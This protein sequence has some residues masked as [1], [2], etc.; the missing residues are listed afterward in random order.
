M[1]EGL[2]SAALK[3][4]LMQFQRL[5]LN[6]I[7]LFLLGSFS[8]KGQTTN[9][10][11]LIDACED[12]TAWTTF[13][14][15]GVVVTQHN[16]SG[17]TGGSVRFDV[18]FAKGSGYGGIIRNCELALPENYE[19]SFMMCAT[20]PVNNFEF[21]VSND[22]SGEDIWWVNNRNY[23]YPK[24][25]KRMTVKKRH[26]AFAWGPHASPKPDRLRRIEIVVTAGTGG[27]GSVW[28]DD[29]RL[30]PIPPVPTIPPRPLVF[31]S[32][33]R[34][35]RA[36]AS[37]IISGDH[38]GWASKSPTAEWLTIDYGYRKEF[39]GVRLAWDSALSGLNYDVLTSTDGIAFD[40]VHTVHNGEGGSVLLYT[41][42]SEA[43]F[44]KLL[45]HG[46]KS[47]RAF[48]LLKID[49]VPSDSLSTVNDY[50][51][52]VA[53][54]SPKGRYPRYFL[55]QASYWTVVGVASDEKEALLNEDGVVEVDKQH[56]SI[57]PY[58]RLNTGE[59]LTWANA[60]EQQS[61][62][63]EYLPIPTAK[64][65]YRDLELSVTVVAYGEPGRSA[66]LA[67]YVLKNTSL[68]HQNGRFFIAVRPFQVNP[69]YQ[70]LNNEGGVA[71]TSL[72]AINGNRAIVGDKTVTVSGKP[73]QSGVTDIDQGDIVSHIA[74][75]K[76]PS[77]SAI[78]D[79]WGMAS[80]GFRY[81]FN[82]QPGDSLVVIAS[83][84]FWPSADRWS[85]SKP[86]KAEFDKEIAVVRAEWIRRLNTVQFSLPPGARKY[87]DVVRSN[88]AYV[89]I[90]KDGPG[91]QPGS[92]SYERSW[93]RDGSMTSAALLKFGA[94][95]DVHNFIQW[96]SG[97]QYENGMV[98]CVVD[99]RGPDPVPENDSHGE[100][101]FACV[102]YFRFTKD[103]LFLR[104]QWSHI[105]AAAEYMQCLRRQ[106]MTVEY[107]SESG[108]RHAFYGLVP[109]SISH[110]GYSAKPM[111]SYWDDFFVL[112]GF[113]DAAAAAEILGERA[114]GR[115][116]DSIAHA[117]RNDFYSSM[118][119]AMQSL[120][121]EYIPGCVE[122]GDFDPTSTS[123][124]LFPCGELKSLPRTALLSTYDRYF[125]WFVQRENGRISWDAFTPYEIR[126]AGTYV[127]LGQKKRANEL[128][129][130]FLSYQR[131]TAWND[132]AEVVWYERS[133]ARFIGD[134][135]HSWVGSDFLNAFRAMF[136]YEID[137]EP[138]LVIGAGLRDEWVHKGLSIKE[139]PTHFGTLSYSIRP[140]DSS[141]VIVDIEGSINAS[142]SPI[143]I[144]VSLLSIPLRASFVDGKNVLPENGFVRV[145]SLP[146][147]VHLSY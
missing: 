35:S 8:A 113:K 126:N 54:R 26:L 76:L 40:T 133:D 94:D 90:N 68:K 82:L 75:G 139:L 80:A 84:P 12:T 120:K 135:P 32:S 106:R 37:N 131:P 39:G 115:A 46:N 112:K 56:F 21:K 49:L 55:K 79:P 128:M 125:D 17:Y 108:G 117:F 81:S 136:A 78:V 58:I 102:E 51:A 103:T 47:R 118:A 123:I 43:R 27:E 24:T 116:Y 124:A 101:I 53:Q 65:I 105:V 119:S 34:G 111:H 110:E 25:W 147:S 77:S 143:L 146:A 134:M 93:I 4:N 1:C 33:R 127:Y 97:Y 98:P 142:L 30:I 36:S 92:R 69:S 5:R 121:I 145:R 63:D 6:Y 11:A 60:R 29:L 23:Q 10:S 61:L 59:L 72:I 13:H 83:I 140:V 70:W 87:Q 57:E 2:W 28:I 137:E 138:M 66:L 144:P 22:S 44:V 95:S 3:A 42:E 38:P 88:L 122:L 132:W 45:L 15:V 7:C 86:S 16:D 89:L 18:D 48:H 73:D 67:Q 91:F 20:V 50:L 99:R 107:R 109:E 31:V 130:W 104:Q 141:A 19:L 62:A 64:R 71:R 96:Y 114:Q 9:G 85:E 52:D 129:D 100:F 74:T 41:P 14:S